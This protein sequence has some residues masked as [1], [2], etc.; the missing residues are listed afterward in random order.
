MTVISKA[1]NSL[2]LVGYHGQPGQGVEKSYQDF[3]VLFTVTS[4]KTFSN[5]G[6]F[7]LLR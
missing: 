6:L 7:F 1:G 4:G 3:G 5:E 2:G